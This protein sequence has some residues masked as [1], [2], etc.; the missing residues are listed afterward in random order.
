MTSNAERQLQVLR[1]LKE[2]SPK[3]RKSL[4][5]HCEPELIKAISEICY[6]YL[7]GNIKCT[8]KQFSVL[9]KHKNC[10]RKLAESA[11]ADSKRVKKNL[12]ASR[13]ILLQKG[14]GFW[15]PLLIPLVTELSSYFISKALQK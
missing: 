10:I 14:N 3:L 15:I 4:L 11:S 8:E 5:L 13:K 9:R 12:E 2:A 7:R 1:V 6:N